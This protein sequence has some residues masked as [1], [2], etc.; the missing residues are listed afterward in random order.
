MLDT[1]VMIGVMVLQ[2]KRPRHDYVLASLNQQLALYLIG[3][4]N[5]NV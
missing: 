5:S 1:V 4:G 3:L 2:S